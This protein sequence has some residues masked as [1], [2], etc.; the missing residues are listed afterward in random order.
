[1]SAVIVIVAIVVL[2]IRDDLKVVPYV[3]KRE[4]TKKEAP[5]SGEPAPSLKSA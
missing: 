1:M 2:Q 4:R 3:R 5:G